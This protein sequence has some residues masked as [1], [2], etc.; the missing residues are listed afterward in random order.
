LERSSWRQQAMRQSPA[1]PRR[2]RCDR[3]PQGRLRLRCW[4]A[5]PIRPASSPRQ[6]HGRR[7]RSRCGALG[8]A[9]AAVALAHA[10]AHAH[11]AALTLLRAALPP[12]APGAAVQVQAV[13]RAPVRHTG[14]D[15]GSG[16]SAGGG[17]CALPRSGRRRGRGGAG[18]RRDGQPAGSVRGCGAQAARRARM[19]ERASSLLATAE[20]AG[21]LHPCGRRPCARGTGRRQR[22]QDTR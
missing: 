18:R 19:S 6:M 3:A 22:P 7:S 1:A 12:C 13:R 10:C 4:R 11:R 16:R 8:A 14:R 2:R 20:S 17:G 15:G 21:V 5:G 9:A